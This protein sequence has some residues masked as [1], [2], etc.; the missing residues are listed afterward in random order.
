MRLKNKV[1]LVTGAA[2]GIG[3]AIA[4]RFAEAGAVVA[5]ADLDK[6]AAACAVAEDRT[7]GRA[8]TPGCDGRHR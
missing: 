5:I 8:R 7:V 4:M 1:A 3:K 6:A 2:S